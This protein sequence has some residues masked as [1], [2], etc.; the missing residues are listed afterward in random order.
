MGLK[1]R[2][3]HLKSILFPRRPKRRIEL[4]NRILVGTHH[5][6]GTVWLQ[7]IF[8]RICQQ[9]GWTMYH[10][11]SAVPPQGCDVFLPW[12]SQFDRAAIQ[13]P[14]KG[15]HL[16]R[17]P[18]DMIVSGCFYHQ[19]ATE[20]WL[21]IKQD[22]LG[23]LSYQEKLNSYRSLSDQILFE[24]EFGSYGCIQQILAWNYNDPAFYEVKY[25]DLI[26][27]E[28]LLLFHDLFVFLEFPGKIIPRTLKIALDNS[29]FAGTTKTNPHIRSG[30][31]RQWEQ[32][33]SP[34]NKARFLELFG[35][36]LQRLGYENSGAWA[37]EY[38]RQQSTDTRPVD[39]PQLRRAA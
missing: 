4:K 1:E 13:P 21:H 28:Q 25:E 36:A 2:F 29:I 7:S 30:K 33:F 37:T 38:P 14:F 27:D 26:A 12:N 39:L 6:A 8:R 34:E 11:E 24:M 35:D 22:S 9:Y 20:K 31:A 23:G 17:D 10:G 32:H 18:R 19:K 5:K 15:I 3:R 16:I